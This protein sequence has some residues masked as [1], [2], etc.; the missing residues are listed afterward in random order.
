MTARHSLTM[1]HQ[2]ECCVIFPSDLHGGS[3]WDSE[4]M[5][6]CTTVSSQISMSGA[7]GHPSEN[8]VHNPWSNL[9]IETHWRTHDK[10]GSVSFS[11]GGLTFI[12]MLSTTSEQSWQANFPQSTAPSKKKLSSPDPGRRHELALASLGPAQRLMQRGTSTPARQ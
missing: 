4:L 6:F 8:S 1:V 3:K 2:G 10:P 12:R 11:H 5:I 7:L 9:D